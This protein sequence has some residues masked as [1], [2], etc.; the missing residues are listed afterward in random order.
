MFFMML[1]AETKASCEREKKFMNSCCS[2]D[3]RRLLTLLALEITIMKNAFNMTIK[4]EQS[5][6][7]FHMLRGSGRGEIDLRLRVAETRRVLID[8]RRRQFNS[9]R[10]CLSLNKQKPRK[11]IRKMLSKKKNVL[12]PRSSNKASRRVKK[13]SQFSACAISDKRARTAC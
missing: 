10:C 2:V 8:S 11:V 12:R 6:R 13:N 3:L 1:E 9:L 7:E 5:I 4:S